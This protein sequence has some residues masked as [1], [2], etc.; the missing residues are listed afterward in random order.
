MADSVVGLSIYL[1]PGMTVEISAPI[2]GRNSQGFFARREDTEP[3]PDN[4][5]E[6]APNASKALINGFSL[7]DTTVGSLA[8]SDQDPNDV[9]YTHEQ[10]YG[11]SIWFFARTG[12]R[13]LVKVISVPIHDHSTIVHGGPA[14][15]TYYDDDSER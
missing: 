14:Y 10:P 4:Y 5:W 11:N 15:G 7:E 9:V 13:G 6:D 8:A 12:E 1:T 2:N 3:L